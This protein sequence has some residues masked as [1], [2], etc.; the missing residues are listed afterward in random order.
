MEY[1]KLTISF[2]VYCRN[3]YSQKAVLDASRH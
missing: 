1:F 3:S 2:H